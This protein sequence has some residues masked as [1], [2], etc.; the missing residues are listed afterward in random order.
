MYQVV[1]APVL[2]KYGFDIATDNSSLLLL[3]LATVLIAAGGYILNDYFDV[4][5]DEINKPEKLIIGRTFSKKQAMRLYQFFSIA[6]IL[7]GLLLAWNLKSLSLGFIFIVV[8][9]SLWFYSA[10]YK[11]QFLIGNLLVSFLAALVVIVVAVVK[12]DILKLEYGNLVLET[13]IPGELYGWMGGFAL[14]SFLT[15]WIREIVK[16]ME[17]QPGDA[18]LEC[19]TMPIVWGIRKTKFFVLAL[20]FVT[21]SLLLICN[22]LYINFESDL[23]LKYIVLLIVIPLLVAGG[24]VFTASSQQAFHQTAT[25]LK[26]IMLSGVM[27]SFVFYYLMAKTYDFSL[28]DMLIVK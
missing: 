9:G 8:P 14:F 24:L 26:I 16:D 22:R 2:Q 1:A 18:E 3:V 7:M 25:F 12:I 10:S 17:D 28:F 27:Y 20:V 21:I 6:G 15:T 13:P 11:R 4:K 23:S 5:I 19:R